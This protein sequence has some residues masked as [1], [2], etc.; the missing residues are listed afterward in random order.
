MPDVHFDDIEISQGTVPNQDTTAPNQET[1]NKNVLSNLY[2][3]K[4]E[5]PITTFKDK[6]IFIA[7]PC[8][9]GQV[10]EPYFRS[11]IK[12]AHLCDKHGIQLSISTIANESLIT[13][14][15]NTLVSFFMEEEKATHL[16]F[17]DADIEFVPEDVIRMVY[18]DKPIIVGAYPKKN[19]DWDTV[20]STAKSGM[21]KSSN[22]LLAHGSKYAI[23]FDLKQDQN[24]THIQIVDNLIKLKD[25][26]TGFMC[27]KRQV[28]QHMF[29]KYAHLKY[30]S[31]INV[32]QKFE[33]HMYALFD[34][35]IE[36]GSLRYLSE[37]YTFCRLWQ[38]IGGE[39][40]LDPRT[41]LNHTG[42]YSFSG[43]IKGFFSRL[44]QS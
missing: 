36:P 6:H 13:R 25:G 15:R 7:T 8:Y 30:N 3:S 5:I 31:D 33:K 22:E 29:E 4:I 11:M 35:M 23:N 40:F 38:D 32:D 26:A 16:F 21:I 10:S 43:N 1:K 39:V 12:L 14:G 24:G 42:F 9:G 18:Y 37:D 28:I 20:F 27:I 19:I 17:I 41:N 34:T 2:D 44:T